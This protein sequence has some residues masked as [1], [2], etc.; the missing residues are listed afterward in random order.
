MF[1]RTT[2]SIDGVAISYA[3]SGTADTAIVLIHGGLA[4][5][6]FW[7]GQH[8]PFSDR[9]RLIA[10]D[11]AGHGESGRDRQKWG[12]VEFAQDVLAVLDAERVPHTGHFPMLERPDEFNRRLAEFI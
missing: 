12:I 4:D 5:R 3:V 11:L 8:A 6:S 9:F 2:R 7:D 1:H 10:L